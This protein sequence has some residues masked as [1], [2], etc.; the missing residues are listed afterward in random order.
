MHKH[1]KD[2]SAPPGS[3][4]TQSLFS[5]LDFGAVGDGVHDDTDAIQ[6]ALHAAGLATRGNYAGVTHGG[7]A[8]L[9]HPTLVFPTGE[10]LITRTLQVASTTIITT[11]TCGRKQLLHFYVRF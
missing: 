5:V 4:P 8:S 9:Q 2:H 7:D 6:A 11:A 10:Y 1:S 3:T